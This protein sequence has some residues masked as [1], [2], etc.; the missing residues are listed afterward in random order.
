MG[1]FSTTITLSQINAAWPG[2]LILT[3]CPTHAPQK[4]STPLEVE[5][6]NWREA[7]MLMLITLLDEDEIHPLDV[8]SLVRELQ[9][10]NI[11]WHHFPI[12]NMCPPDAATIP[13]LE[14]LLMEA[15][16]ILAT[17]GMVSIHCHAGLGRT[18]LVAS[19]LLTSIGMAPTDAIKTIRAYRPGSIETRS[20]E[21]FVRNWG[22]RLPE[23]P[24]G[25]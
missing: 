25:L 14:N 1:D 21:D 5:I 15:A 6:S 20:Q 18:G 8:M 24:P 4:G 17:G 11:A 2:A 12:Q 22:F 16:E 9:A 19:T 10:N 13:H 23:F 3:A 7:A